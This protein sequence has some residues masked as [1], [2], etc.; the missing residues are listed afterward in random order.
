MGILIALGALSNV[1]GQSAL[2]GTN[3]RPNTGTPVEPGEPGYVEPGEVGPGTTATSD[4][5]TN[6]NRAFF[7]PKVI[8]MVFL[9]LVG[10]FTVAQLTKPVS[11]G[12]P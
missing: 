10:A 2:T 6:L 3:A 12:W 9:L 1:F 7:H 5:N 8:G 11:K 4:F